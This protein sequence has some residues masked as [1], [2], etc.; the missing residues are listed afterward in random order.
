L[1]LTTKAAWKAGGGINIRNNRAFSKPPGFEKA[2]AGGENRALGRF[3]QSFFL[4]EALS[5]L[6]F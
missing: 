1:G 2:P 6:R 4:K 3:F 5:K